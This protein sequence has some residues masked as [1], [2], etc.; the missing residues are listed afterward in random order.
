VDSAG[1]RYFQIVS[2]GQASTSPTYDLDMI[3]LTG[4]SPMQVIHNLPDI[5]NLN[6]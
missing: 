6:L 3:D 5:T 4:S 2:S 1:K